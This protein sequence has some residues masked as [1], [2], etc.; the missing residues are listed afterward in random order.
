MVFLALG[1]PGVVFGLF[2]YITVREPARGAMDKRLNDSNPV[3]VV[4]LSETIRFLWQQKAAMHLM[5][6][7][8]IAA[9]WGWGLLWF[10]PTFLERAYGLTTGEAGGVM[11]PIHLYAGTG[12]TLLAAAVLFLPHL[13]HPK[14]LMWML[15]IVVALSTIPSFYAY[16]T[17]SQS[18]TVLM[19]WVF[20]P[21]IYLYIGPT[22]GLLNNLAPPAMRS[23]MIAISLLMGNVTNLIIA[24]QM[25]GLISDGVAGPSGPTAESLRFALLILAPTGFWAALHYFLAIRHYAADHERAVAYG[26]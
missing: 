24:V 10:T 16:Y 18:V 8:A 9:L 20:I 26:S 19:L 1:V 5:M 21:A 3:K 22:M 2:I 25:V 6:G 17:M 13:Q 11:G 4:P 7:G 15:A 14:R 23:Q 12:A